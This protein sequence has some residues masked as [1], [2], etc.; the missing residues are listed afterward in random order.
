M[1]INYI[2]LS[3]IPSKN[4]NALQIVQMC[5]AMVKLGHYVTLLMPNLGKSE[6]SIKEY[7]GIS[8]N[9]NIK[10]IGKK[11]KKFQNLKIY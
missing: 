5:N 2:A 4:A 1:H 10:V 6:K 7:Y 8:S 11:K 9:I 3:D